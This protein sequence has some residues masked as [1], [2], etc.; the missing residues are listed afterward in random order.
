MW[1]KDC[2]EG[3]GRWVVSGHTSQRPY[4][5]RFYWVTQQIRLE[6]QLNLGFPEPGSE[7]SQAE[8]CVRCEAEIG[9]FK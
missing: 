9:V 8:N 1:D 5:D 3:S 6:K 7:E 4:K 2:Y